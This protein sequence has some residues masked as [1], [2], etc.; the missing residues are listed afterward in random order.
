MPH[1]IN[2]K[3]IGELLQEWDRVSPI[4]ELM[5]WDLDTDCYEWTKHR[6]RKGYATVKINGK[7]VYVTRYLLG[8]L[9]RED[10][11][12]V[13]ASH[14]CDN[15]PC[16]N[17][18][19]I[20]ISSTTDN[21]KRAYAVGHLDHKGINNGFSKI[22]DEQVM[23]IYNRAHLGLELQEDIGA[24]YGVS[25]GTVSDIKRGKAWNHITHHR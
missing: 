1:K 8:L 10:F 12:F 11:R 24:D 9:D 22:T 6:A 7:Q 5:N 19:H 13:Q 23:D 16:V 14:L 15:P 3:R 20:I 4:P 25:Y 18:R 17:P 21:N 2:G